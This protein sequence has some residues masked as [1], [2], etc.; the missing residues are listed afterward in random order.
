MMQL[1]CGADGENG[2]LIPSSIFKVIRR[3]EGGKVWQ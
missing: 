1:L 2:E 3:G